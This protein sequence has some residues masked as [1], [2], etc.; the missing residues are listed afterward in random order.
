MRPASR[1]LHLAAASIS[2]AVLQ[3]W[4]RLE[5]FAKAHGS[6]IG[7]T[8]ADLGLRSGA[9]RTPADIEAAAR[10]SVRDAGLIVRDL[11]IAVGLYAAVALEKA[12]RLQPQTLPTDRIG[13]ER[14]LTAHLPSHRRAG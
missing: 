1:T 3:A 6:G 13:L 2:A 11:P 12:A 5:A 8:L 9:P 7:R 4:C 14:L 10:C